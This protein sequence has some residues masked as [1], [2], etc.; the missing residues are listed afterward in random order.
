MAIGPARVEPRPNKRME[1]TMTKRVGLF[2]MIGLV[3]SFGATALW[4]DELVAA[5]KQICQG[6][7]ACKS[8]TAK[9]ATDSRIDA[10]GT[11]MESKGTGMIELLRKGGKL[12]MRMELKTTMPQPAGGDEKVEQSMLS[13][14]DGEYNWTLSE[15]MGQK[16]AMKTKPDPRATGDP[17]ALFEELRKDNEL[18]LLPE[19]TV[20]GKKTFVIEA[21][22]KDKAAGTKSLLYFDKERGAMLKMVTLSADGKPMWTMTYSDVKYDADIS[23]DRFV[24]KAPPD[25]EVQDMTKLEMSKPETPEKHE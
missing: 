16:M 10:G 23:P 13:I 20:D 1:L 11:I 24:F 5:E 4:A 22:P 17:K 12:C 8:L 25:V 21:T 2:L 3:C 9:V 14:M 6:W 18:K 7:D 15:T 19:E